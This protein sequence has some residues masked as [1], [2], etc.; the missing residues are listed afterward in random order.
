MTA[1]V[2]VFS[3]PVE[4]R[5]QEYNDWY[6]NVHLQEVAAVDG[7]LSAQRFELAETQVFDNQQHRYVAIYEI[8]ENY[9]T[10]AAVENM[11]TGRD[12]MRMSDAMDLD[13]A[14]VAVVS[15]ITDI[16]R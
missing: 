13:N 5:E 16:V 6:D 8:D 3:N 9:G 1:Y 12:A 11:L 4:G 15:S 14:K 2:L 7:I 10:G